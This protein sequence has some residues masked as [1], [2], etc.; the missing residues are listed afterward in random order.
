VS[1]FFLAGV[2]WRKLGN[3][4]SAPCDLNGLAFRGPLEQLIEV[5]FG[6]ERTYGFHASIISHNKLVDQ[7][8]GSY[9]LKL[10]KG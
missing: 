5:S 10:P 2:W 9:L 8:V 6:V 3:R 1:V 7:L 4:D